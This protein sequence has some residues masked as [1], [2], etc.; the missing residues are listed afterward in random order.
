MDNLSARIIEL[1]SGVY[2]IPGS[3]NVG[4]ITN[5]VTSSNNET[6]A[7]SIEVY[8]VDSGCTEIDGEYVL[9]VLK[10]FF[11]QLGQDFRLKAILTTHGHADHCGAHNFLKDETGCELWASKNEAGHME[12]P[13]VQAAT[14]WGGYPPHEL[15]TL[16][17]MP[18]STKVDRFISDAD[19]IELLIT[20]GI[21]KG[22]YNT[23][24][25]LKDVQYVKPTNKLSYFRDIPN[26]DVSPV[27]AHMLINSKNSFTIKSM[28]NCISSLIMSLTQKGFISVEPGQSKNDTTISITNL[29][30]NPKE[31]FTTDEKKLYNYL[32]CIGQ[33]FTL[34]QFNKYINSHQE[35][36]YNLLEYI[37][38]ENKRVLDSSQY[39]NATN[40]KAKSSLINYSTL[41]FILSFSLVFISL[42]LVAYGLNI[43]YLFVLVLFIILLLGSVYCFIKSKRI[44]IFSQTG[45]DEKEEWIGLKKFMTDFSLL[46]EREI[47]EL[48]LWEKYLVYA[49]AFGIADKVL[50]QLKTKFPELNDENYIRD[51]YTCMYMASHPHIYHNSF[52]KSVSSAQ[53]YH[54][55][56]VAVSSMSS[57]SGGGGGFS[58]GGGGRRPA[59]V[60]AVAVKNNK[61]KGQC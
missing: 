32:G 6:A 7:P 22:L 25:S 10:A 12:T 1:A 19:V 17:F 30:E 58:S 8:L 44:P 61:Y 26:S 14:L 54:S 52:S 23:L 37:K 33:K 35:S 40:K 49:T 51:H 56:Q 15:R 50:K 29:D 18:A 45:I 39:T 36:F 21:F 28:P 38:N 24:K 59:E 2:V 47:P 41:L 46:K 27:T 11:E 55:A 31:S 3:T 60:A 53:S 42:L 57:G 20:F 48:V 5:E 4:V 13:I 16:F 43:N 9:D 34:K